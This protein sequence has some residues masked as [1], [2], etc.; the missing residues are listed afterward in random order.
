MSN[1]A[2]SSRENEL[3]VLRR[4][5]P[6]PPIPLDLAHPRTGKVREFELQQAASSEAM[7]SLQNKKELLEGI[8]EPYCSIP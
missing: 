8:S 2:L 5:L 4:K 3:E 7:S 6:A 1:G